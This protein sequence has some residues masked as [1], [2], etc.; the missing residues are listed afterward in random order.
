MGAV[1]GS[2]LVFDEFHLFPQEARK[3]T[4]QLLRTVGKIAPFVLMTATFS[5]TMLDEIGHLLGATVITVPEAEVEAIETRRGEAT[6][7]Q[8][9]YR[10]ADVPLEAK[11]VLQTHDR[12]TLAVCNTVD[13]AIGLF[14]D[15]LTQGCRS[16]PFGDIIP[17][18]D[19]EN[20]RAAREPDARQKLLRQ[21][22][23]RVQEYLYQSPDENWAMLLHSRF[24]RPH[25]Q[26]KEELLQTLWNPEG[27]TSNEAPR[28]IVVGT[29]VVEV[30]LDIS[31]Q[32]LH[33][34][35]APAAS[36]L[37]RAG[38]CARYPGEQGTV[39]LYPVPEN[40]RG[41]PNYAPYGMDKIEKET[42]ERSWEAFRKRDGE[43]LHF[44]NEQ[45]LINEAH[46]DADRALLQAMHED[47]GSIWGQIADALTFHDASTRQNL[48][49]KTTTSRTV[50][51]YDAPLGMTE[52]NPFVF[53]GFSLHI[54]TL[55]GKLEELQKKQK[56]LGLAWSLRYVQPRDDE[57]DPD[58]PPLYY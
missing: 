35:A 33:T 34:E 54:G 50:I 52:E 43:V 58:A 42:C 25:R 55:R 37:Q 45:E 53:N 20:L 23:E 44:A 15:L 31:A 18:E 46:T 57:N 14:D 40:K 51:V 22:V 28:L 36:V 30:G 39:Y 5:Q 3:T 24:E 49:R 1:L 19:F 41:E 56:E 7:K 4:L 26:V 12:R 48:I 13:R 21:A 16:I 38:R 29:Q 32:T 9:R 17:S 47:E 6:R 10:V 11:D 8:R 2:Y 27:L